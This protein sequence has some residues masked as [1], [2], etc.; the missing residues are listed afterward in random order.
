MIYCVVVG[1]VVGVSLGLAV[2]IYLMG[3]RS[4]PRVTVDWD[5]LKQ[6]LTESGRITV[7]SQVNVDW[8][9]IARLLH[10]EDLM[11]VPKGRVH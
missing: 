1:A 7:H 3:K 4:P 10:A 2:G 8:A 6:G 5:A 11:I 9:L